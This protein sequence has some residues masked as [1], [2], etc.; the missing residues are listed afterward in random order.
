MLLFP[1]NLW[2][3]DVLYSKY[4]GLLWY[5]AYK[6]AF[7]SSLKSRSQLLTEE[8]K[9]LIEVGTKYNVWIKGLYYNYKK[10]C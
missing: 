7:L 4:Q 9:N 2:R 8:S 3:L 5:Y 1:K 10:T 6:I